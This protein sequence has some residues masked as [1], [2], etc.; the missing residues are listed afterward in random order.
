MS[1]TILKVL[2]LAESLNYFTI[3]DAQRG[4]WFIVPLLPVFILD[5]I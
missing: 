5:F 3:I 4:V 1:A 2:L